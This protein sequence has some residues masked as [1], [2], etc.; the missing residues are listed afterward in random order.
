MPVAVIMLATMIMPVTLFMAVARSGAVGMSVTLRVIGVNMPVR[1]MLVIIGVCVRGRAWHHLTEPRKRVVAAIARHIGEERARLASSRI[2]SYSVDLNLGD[3]DTLD[4]LVEL[5]VEQE[6]EPCALNGIE[7][8]DLLRIIGGKKSGPAKRLIG[9][10]LG[11][12]GPPSL[13][14]AADLQESS[15]VR[16]G[17]YGVFSRPEADHLLL[18][19]SHNRCRRHG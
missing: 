8:V 15:A 9:E 4:A 19:A 3:L 12:I 14:D 18:F 11:E 5:V 13:A 1:G 17:Q 7:R 10:D 2:S 6:P 16:V